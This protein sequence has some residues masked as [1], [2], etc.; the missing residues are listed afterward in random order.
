MKQRKFIGARRQLEKVNDSIPM[1]LQDLAHVNQNNGGK[2]FSNFDFSQIKM[3]PTGGFTT[4]AKKK[5]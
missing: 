5:K 4:T 1:D 3:K 2:V